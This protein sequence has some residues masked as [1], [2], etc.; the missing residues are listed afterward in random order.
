M[1]ANEDPGYTT[2]PSEASRRVFL[3][4]TSDQNGNRDMVGSREKG[5]GVYFNS[6]LNFH[7]LEDIVHL[8]ARLERF[9]R[10]YCADGL[11][12]AV[13]MVGLQLREI[14]ELNQ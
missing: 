4:R 9:I 7:D 12:E 14:Q 11:K 2:S 1:R 3:L 5:M 13:R 10:S 6:R 8:S